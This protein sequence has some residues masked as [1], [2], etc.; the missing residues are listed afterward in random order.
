MTM[1]MIMKN[2]SLNSSKDDF[3]HALALRS[4]YEEII[5]TNSF[6]LSS[7]N[8][9]IDNLRWFRKNGHKSNRFRN[10]F[11]EAKQIANY[12]IEYYDENFNLS[13]VHRKAL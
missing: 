12:I 4:R 2:T 5:R 9:D 7:L 1:N 13:G 3:F 10:D 6:N 8:S 11:N